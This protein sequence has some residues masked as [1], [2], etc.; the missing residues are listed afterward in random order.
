VQKIYT[1]SPFSFLLSCPFSLVL[2]D[3]YVVF[4]FSAEHF[5][6]PSVDVLVKCWPTWIR[7]VVLVF[8][9]SR[10]LPLREECVENAKT[11]VRRV[12]LLFQIWTMYLSNMKQDCFSFD[13]DVQWQAVV[14]II[15]NNLFYY[16]REIVEWLN[17]NYKIIDNYLLRKNFA[18]WNKSASDCKQFLTIGIPLSINACNDF[19]HDLVY[20]TSCKRVIPH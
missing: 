9:S 3:V 14:N 7:C 4:L 19:P 8:F 17:D 16:W 1:L 10:G 13:R 20:V 11:S 2:A 5:L 18:V 12:G 15:M 6:S